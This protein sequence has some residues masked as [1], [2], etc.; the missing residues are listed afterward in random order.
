MGVPLVK[1]V[2]HNVKAD[3]YIRIHHAKI[4]VQ[5]LKICG[6]N[7]RLLH[8]A[9][10]LLINPTWACYKVNLVSATANSWVT[11]WEQTLNKGP[12]WHFPPNTFLFKTNKINQNDKLYFTTFP[13]N[14]IIVDCSTNHLLVTTQET[15][16][17]DTFTPV[18]Q[19]SLRFK[20]VTS[21]EYH[22]DISWGIS[23]P[24]LLH[25]THIC[26]SG[27]ENFRGLTRLECECIYV[28]I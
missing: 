25:F 19:W 17:V 14:F 1:E 27:S 13:H 28:K 10:G 3:P 5:K 16:L 22:D 11:R 15:S 7:P 21:K 9:G 26:M 23:T 24:I 2:T 4:I 18:H 6:T 20:A 12:L 8:H